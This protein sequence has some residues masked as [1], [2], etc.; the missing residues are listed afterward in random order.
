MS[1]RLFFATAVLASVIL[2]ALAFV[3]PQGFGRPA[4]HPFGHPQVLS[5]AAQA[6]IAQAAK[7]KPTKGAAQPATTTSKK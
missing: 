5:A 4:P 3:W 6:D 1:D 7:P 2:I